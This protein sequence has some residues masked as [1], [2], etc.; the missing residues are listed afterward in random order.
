MQTD[1]LKKILEQIQN[2]E[3]SVEDAMSSLKSFPTDDIGFAKLDTH[4]SLRNGF[5]EVI[6]CKGKTDDQIVSIFQALT[7]SN[8][9]IIGTLASED[10]FKHIQKNISTAVYHKQARIIQIGKTPNPKTK[11]IITIVTGGTSDIPVAEEAAVTAETMG[12]KVVRLYDIGVAG[13]HRMLDN[14]K[15]L[16]NSNVIIAVA[17]MEGALA[18]VVSGLVACPV[19]G[20][21]TSVGY[22]SSFEGLSA[23]LS[24]LNSCAPGIAVVNIDNGFGAGYMAS[25]IN[26]QGVKL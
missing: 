8:N 9:L 26:L 18:T 14:K 1:N 20:V 19:I 22:G 5:P 7:K 12:N 25:V 23:L 15:Q 13:I 10:T 16:D 2:G 11:K 24:M 17:G 3:I 21:P 4:R 6:F